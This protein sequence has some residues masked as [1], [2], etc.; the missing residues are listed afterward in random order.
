VSGDAEANI[1]APE[2]L[3]GMNSGDSIRL[4]ALGTL[5]KPIHAVGWRRVRLA[6]YTV[7][8]GV[9]AWL[10]LN[11]GIPTGRTNLAAMLMIA[12]LLTSLG[13]G[14]RAA[15]RVIVDWLPFTA[16]LLLYDETRGVAYRLG[17]GLHE[18]DILHA[19][20]WLFGGTEPSLWLQ[21]HLY[22]PAHIY[23][24]DVVCTL[25]YT[26][27][28]LTTPILAAILWLRD[29]TLWVRYISR[30]VVLSAA[31]LIT[32]CLFPEAPPWLAGRDGFSPAVARIS[33]RG[34]VPLHFESLQ[35]A[36]SKAQDG[37]SNPIAAMPSLHLAFATLAVIAVGA[38]LRSRWRT[39]LALYPLAMGFVLVYCGEHYVLDLIAG[40]AYA[41]IT[42]YALKAW[43][44]RRARRRPRADFAVPLDDVEQWRPAELR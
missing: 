31:G 20:K 10:T 39:L 1:R 33:T 34:W 15:L 41:L 40:L 37:G 11:H 35:D 7:Y 23:W 19:E 28:F 44:R 42:H 36:L 14:W 26:S 30:V 25:I 21:Q 24:Y 12:L 17:I 8:G 43:E 38:Q 29:R 22:N 5:L 2:H 32:Y 18:T 3:E 27:H 4:T 9:V 16:M 6:A 13:R